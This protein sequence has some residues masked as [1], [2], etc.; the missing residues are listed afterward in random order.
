MHVYRRR[1]ADRFHA[2]ARDSV[3]S[4]CIL[5]TGSRYEVRRGDA[6]QDHDD[7]KPQS[8]PAALTRADPAFEILVHDETRASAT[9]DVRP[10][11]SPHVDRVAGPSIDT[12]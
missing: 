4:R 6:E 1:S 5:H 8:A 12:K 9:L 2:G 3:A 7:R 11:V 10:D